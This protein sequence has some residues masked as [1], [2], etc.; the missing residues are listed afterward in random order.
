[1][2]N[3]TDHTA[4]APAWDYSKST[5]ANEAARLGAESEAAR[6]RA[7]AA[8]HDQDAADSFDR[9]DT[10]GFVS[11]WASGQMADLRRREAELAEHGGTWTF[12]RTELVTL[13]GQPTDAREVQTRFGAKWRLDSTDQWLPVAPKREATL[14]KHGYREVT[15]TEVAPAKAAHSGSGKGLAGA[16]SVSVVIYRA[17]G[18]KGW[19]P[20]GAPEA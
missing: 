8:Q 13:D 2:T 19:R 9:C 12:A 18:V 3:H 20:V 6:L 14:A 17:D 5:W 10:D 11:Q 1:M 7:E 4:A 16:T 15:T